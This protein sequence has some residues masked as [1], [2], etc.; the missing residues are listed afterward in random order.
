M[1][2]IVRALAEALFDLPEGAEWE[3]RI[4]WLLGEVDDLLRHGGPRARAIFLGSLTVVEG[5]APLLAGHRPPFHRLPRS[6]RLEALEALERNGP[7]ALTLFAAKALL[8][9]VWF[10]HPSTAA[11]SGFDGRCQDGSERLP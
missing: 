3:H 6:A 4:V 8:A 7:A 9:I 5:I 10:E 1:R 2:P 11:E